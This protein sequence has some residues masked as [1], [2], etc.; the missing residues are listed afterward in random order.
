MH[1]SKPD[2]S[3]RWR[4]PVRRFLRRLERLTLRIEAPIARWVGDARFNPLY[5]T[6]TLAVFL[7][8]ILAF[9]GVYL[10]MFYQFG[11]EDAYNAVAATNRNLIGHLIR[12]VHR[13]ASAALMLTALLHAWRTFVQDRFRGP[14]FIAWFSGVLVTALVWFIGV[15]GYWLIWDGRAHLLNASL[16]RLLQ[17]WQAGQHFL[18]RFVAGKPAGSGWPF[19]FMLLSAHF[20]LTLLIFFFLLYLH[21]R[22]LSRPKWMPPGYWS[23]GGLVVLLLVAV[24]FPVEMLSAWDPAQFP[25]RVPLDAF[26]LGYLPAALDWPVWAF[27]GLVAGILTLLAVLPRF[28]QRS[29]PRPV[30]LDL[31]ACD[32]CTLC[33]RDCPYNA[34]KMAPR[35]DGA[36]HKFQAEVNPDRCVA[37]GICVGSCPEGALS[38]NGVVP[39]R[40]RQGEASLLGGMAA[41]KVVFTCERH[42]LQADSTALEQLVSPDGD[43]VSVIPLTCLGMA[44]PDLAVQALEHGAQEVH[45]VGCPAEDCANREGNLWLEERLQRKRL[46]NLPAPWQ[47]APIYRHYLPPLALQVPA[48]PPTA[49][50]LP[51]KDVAWKRFLPGLGLLFLVL[52]GQV[53]LTRLPLPV[54]AVQQAWVQV[55]LPHRSGYPVEGGLQELEPQPGNAPIRL[56]LE[57]DGTPLWQ[58]VYSGGRAFAFG[59]ATFPSGE[60]HIRLLLRDRPDESQVQVLFDDVL[61]LAPGQVLNLDYQDAS[62]GSDPEAGRRLF[63]E[64]SLGT[65]AGCRICH[66]LEPGVRLVGPS[67]AGVATRAATRVPGMSAEEYLRQSI[68]E[69]DAYVVEGYPA[70]QMVPHLGDILSKEQVD[71]LVA[72]LMTL[73]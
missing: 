54:R 60:H 43:S 2:W 15:T 64:N 18:V 49:Y 3:T 31:A 20:V 16:M 45:F 56:T 10:T 55:T 53:F 41:S 39:H 8:T 34:I 38:L 36:R 26:Y 4:T 57:V 73:K 46:P 29:V 28:F 24:L 62:L 11:F 44:H 52:V 68:L 23:L 59:Q 48:A 9:T 13:Y 12:G 58:E 67:L 65:N 40:A 35:T 7:L 71:D 42:A 30:V 33:A 5:H 61:T 27:W 72:F 37:C 63:Y 69:P 32:G 6:G 47:D 1:F 25:S 50:T 14:R 51:W 22:G 21:F 19:V 66:S 17:S 70:G